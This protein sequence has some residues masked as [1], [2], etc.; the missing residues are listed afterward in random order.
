[1]PF[2]EMDVSVTMTGEEWVVLMARIVGKPL[3]KKG[4]KI[5]TIA[6]IKLTDQLTAASDAN[7]S[8]TKKPADFFEGR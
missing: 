4:G 6:C 1:M 5:Y 8:A 7:P 3:S 2:P